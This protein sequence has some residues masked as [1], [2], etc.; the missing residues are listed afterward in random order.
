VHPP[1]EVKKVEQYMPGPGAYDPGQRPDVHRSRKS[2]FGLLLKPKR[3]TALDE[4]GPAS[5]DVKLP[6]KSGGTISRSSAPSDVELAMK[7]SAETPGPG[8]YE[9]NS[10]ASVKSSTITGRT[11][12][13]NDLMLAMAAR[14]P[15]PGAYDLPGARVRGGTT[16]AVR[17]PCTRGSARRR[18]RAERCHRHRPLRFLPMGLPLEPRRTT[19]LGEAFE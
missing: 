5:Y 4:P 12:N 3:D 1:T 7:K 11:R 18:G 13:E 16:E 10:L 8:T 19:R 9:L 17:V 14:R 15:G 6:V 2:S